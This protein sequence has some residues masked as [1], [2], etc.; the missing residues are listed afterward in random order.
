MGF[1]I[2]QTYA[3][4]LMYKGFWVHFLLDE[5]FYC[6]WLEELIRIYL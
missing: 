3:Q 4:A 6:P 1:A 5:Q 2:L